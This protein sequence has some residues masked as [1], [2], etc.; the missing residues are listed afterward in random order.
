MN[1]FF[2]QV[3]KKNY[4][5]FKRIMAENDIFIINKNIT[6]NNSPNDVMKLGVFV[7]FTADVKS[8]NSKTDRAA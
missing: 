4:H 5:F 7:N 3:E 2:Y 1:I 8:V 6:P